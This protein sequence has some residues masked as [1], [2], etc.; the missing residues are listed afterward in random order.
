MGSAGGGMRDST[1][2]TTEG[3]VQGRGGQRCVRKGR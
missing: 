1:G 3:D 2:G